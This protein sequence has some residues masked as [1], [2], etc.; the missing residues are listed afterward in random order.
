MKKFVVISLL[1]AITA[2]V[3]SCSHGEELGRNAYP[4]VSHLVF[5]ENN[6]YGIKNLN[7]EIIVKA[8]YENSPTKVFDG[9]FFVIPNGEKEYSLYNVNNIEKPIAKGFS[10]VL[11]FTNDT[12]IVT[13]NGCTEIY[14]IDKQGKELK[15]ISMSGVIAVKPILDGAAIFTD[16]NGKRGI[17]Q[18]GNQSLSER[19]FDYCS[20]FS[21][22]IALAIE[23]RKI[24]Y[25]NKK[26]ETIINYSTDLTWN[27]V[28]DEDCSSFSPEWLPYVDDNTKTMGVKDAQGNIV[29][30]SGRYKHIGFI[31]DGYA[32]AWDGNKNYII[33][34]SG[35]EILSDEGRLSYYGNNIVA[36]MTGSVDNY[37]I[38]DF[39]NK[40]IL[41]TKNFSFD[42]YTGFISK[43]DNVNGLWNRKI[44]SSNICFLGV[45]DLKIAL[46]VKHVTDI[47]IFNGI[48]LGDNVYE[49]EAN[50]KVYYN[51]EKKTWKLSTIDNPETIYGL[52][53]STPIN[54]TEVIVSNDMIVAL[55]MTI[56]IGARTLLVGGNTIS[57]FEEIRNTLNNELG[58]P[59]KGDHAYSLWQDGKRTVILGLIPA[60]LPI[61][62]IC[63]RGNG[64]S[65]K[66]ILGS[67]DF[68]FPND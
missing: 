18:L 55:N 57:Y 50:K 52:K 34:S 8:E 28:K 63:I 58:E 36:Y 24:D 10:S 12:T 39:K 46:P 62:Q 30:E 4:Q 29:I 47:E 60:D 48:Y 9:L 35:K 26:G 54:S 65:T 3:S 7:E 16:T 21:N 49:H 14:L 20:N 32:L 27:D 64:Q 1:A 41:T 13:K 31:H 33:D 2:I 61:A 38:K 56:A 15:K 5:L 11:P 45:K 67:S 51:E 6:R 66:E 42:P 22:G 17:F 23:G 43:N 25:I 37:E 40:L 68:I 53:I 59:Q 19:R 44:Y